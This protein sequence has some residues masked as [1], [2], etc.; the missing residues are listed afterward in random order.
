[1]GGVGLS[2]GGEVTRE[3]EILW[4]YPLFTLHASLRTKSAFVI[5]SSRGCYDYVVD[6]T[7]RAEP[8]IPYKEYE[9]QGLPLVY[10]LQSVQPV[11]G[12]VSSSFS[13]GALSPTHSC[14]LAQ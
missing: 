5:T 12:L 4:L 1:M 11:G 9:M 10:I 3:R 14:E 8:A 6:V 2:G 13:A 7:A